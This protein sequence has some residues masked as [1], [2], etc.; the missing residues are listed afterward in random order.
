MNSNDFQPDVSNQS[1]SDEWW[2]TFVP[3][4]SPPGGDTITTCRRYNT[5]S[6]RI[7]VRME[8]SGRMRVG[9][10]KPIRVSTVHRLFIGCTTSLV[11]MFGRVCTELMHSTFISL[12]VWKIWKK[13]FRISRGKVYHVFNHS[14]NPSRM[15]TCLCVC[16]R[17]VRLL[18]I[19]V[20]QTAVVRCTVL[21]AS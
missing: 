12:G 20:F 7:E 18:C 1:A 2:K 16:M 19:M 9:M 8:V 13:L 21:H 11:G 6:E 14:S 4:P 3:L 17:L 10:W 5:R 15:I